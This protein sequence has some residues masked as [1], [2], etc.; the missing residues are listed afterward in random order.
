M[1]KENNSLLVDTV[2]KSPTP[3]RYILI[4][5]FSLLTGFVAL[6]LSYGLNFSAAGQFLF[7]AAMYLLQVAYYEISTRLKRKSRG[8]DADISLF[9]MPER[10][11][12]ADF[13]KLRKHQNNK[14]KR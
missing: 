5:I 12:I 1:R 8:Y 13:E 6:V 9:D 14:E 11:D 2:Y 7:V 10:N 4:S 3:Y